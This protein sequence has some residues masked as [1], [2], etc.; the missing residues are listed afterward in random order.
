L[1]FL[2]RTLQD[3]RLSAQSSGTLWKADFRSKGVSAQL[4]WQPGKD[5]KPGR[6]SGRIPQLTIPDP[7]QQIT[8]IARL[9]DSADDQLPALA[10]VID[11]ISV[12]GH[13]WGSVT[14]DADNR[15]GYWNAKFTVHNEDGNLSGDGRWR[16]DPKQH[17][18]Q[19][20]FRLK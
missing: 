19:I 11:N 12:R 18:T 20:N 7:N 17:D 3:V 15:G 4:D 13:D 5:G 9:Q 2:N 6:I 1:I 16:A 8:E 10:L 14:L